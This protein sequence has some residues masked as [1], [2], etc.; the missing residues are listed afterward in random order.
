MIENIG[1]R[2]TNHTKDYEVVGSHDRTQLHLLREHN[3]EEE[4]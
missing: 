3:K 2:K 4:K 1:N